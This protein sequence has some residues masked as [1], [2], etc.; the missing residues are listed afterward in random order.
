[1]FNTA[2][3]HISSLKKIVNNILIDALKIA[4]KVKNNGLFAEKKN[5]TKNFENNCENDGEIS[6]YYQSI[7]KKINCY[8]KWDIAD[9]EYLKSLPEK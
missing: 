8:S 6:D 1:M 5:S 2:T 4:N 7:L 3:I 9:F